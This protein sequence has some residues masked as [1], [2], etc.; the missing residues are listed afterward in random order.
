M[1]REVAFSVIVYDNY[2]Y[3]HQAASRFMGGCSQISLFLVLISYCGWWLP[4]VTARSCICFGHS[5]H[6]VA[7]I[8]THHLIPVGYVLLELEGVYYRTAQVWF[9]VP[10]TESSMTMKGCLCSVWIF[11]W[12]NDLRWSQK[13]IQTQRGVLGSQSGNL[14]SFEL[15][16]SWCVAFMYEWPVLGQWPVPVQ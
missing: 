15:F 7:Q 14:S 5:S 4:Q 1:K 16:H 9:W 8:Y 6:F 13:Y 12:V 10:C 11:F 3:L 2:Q